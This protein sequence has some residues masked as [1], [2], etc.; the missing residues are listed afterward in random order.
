VA[1]AVFSDVG[2]TALVL[3]VPDAEPLVRGW[4]A[5]HDPSAAEGL[6]AHI[7]VL[8]PFVP[9]GNLTEATYGT[10]GRIC[11]ERSAMTIT[12]E[13]V[14]RFPSVLWLDPGSIECTRLLA[15]VRLRWPE[16]PPYGRSNTEPIPHLTVTDGADEATTLEADAHGRRGLP[17][18]TS[19]ASLSLMVFDGAAWANRRQ[20][21]FA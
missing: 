9:E 7:T 5:A 16:C 3:L 20:F 1:N 6:P 15:T 18:E 8:Y 14:G 4:R 21:E 12:F 13:K 2:D 17:L 10:L 11:R 19:I